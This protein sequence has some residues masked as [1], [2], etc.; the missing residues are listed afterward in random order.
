VHRLLPLDEFDQA[1]ALRHRAEHRGLELPEETLTFLTRR[2]PR[3]FAALCRLL[4]ELDL[5]S[6]AA[7]RRLTVPFVRD[8]LARDAD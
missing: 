6:L 4:D 7:Q 1:E 3:D 8:W 2:A 5:E